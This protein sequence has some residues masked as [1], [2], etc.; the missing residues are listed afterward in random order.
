MMTQAAHTDDRLGLALEPDSVLES[1][2]LPKK[3]L[4][5]AKSLTMIQNYIEYFILACAEGMP[6]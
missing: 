3:S 5:L 1:Q 6:G 2:R 4:S